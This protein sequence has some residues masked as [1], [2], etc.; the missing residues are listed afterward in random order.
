MR[1]SIHD[2]MTF[3]RRFWS[4]LRYVSGVLIV[5]ILLML[6]GGLLFAWWEGRDVGDA[7]YFAF[8][9]GLTVGYGDIAPT[10]LFGRIISIFIGLTGMIFMGVTVAVATRALADSFQIGSEAPPKKT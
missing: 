2:F 4:Y 8:I 5:L 6:A 10:T 1:K 3:M 7:I 9:T